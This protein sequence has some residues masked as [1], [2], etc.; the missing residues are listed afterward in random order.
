MH[1]SILPLEIHFIVSIVIQ[2]SGKLFITFSLYIINNLFS[3]RIPKN[4]T[5]EA[6]YLSFLQ[7]CVQSLSVHLEHL[8]A[9]FVISE[10]RSG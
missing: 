9:T 3:I 10:K 2:I 6:L 7:Y 4:R 8:R 1:I 5:Y